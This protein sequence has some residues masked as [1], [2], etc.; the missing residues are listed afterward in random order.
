MII[1]VKDEIQLTKLKTEADCEI[2]WGE[3]QTSK[4][5]VIIGAFYRP[6]YTD[7]EKLN[8]LD[9]SIQEITN[10]SKG[11][12]IILGGDFN[13]AHINWEYYEFKSGH[14]KAKEK[15]HHEKL[16]DIC[17][18]SDHSLEQMQTKSK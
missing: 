7:I 10:K 1:A 12:M 4:G 17:S 13:L 9:N 2:K 14:P 11:K 16:L 5:K 8:Q 6:P 15:E 3:I 18:C